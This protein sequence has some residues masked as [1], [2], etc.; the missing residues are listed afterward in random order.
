MCVDQQAVAP[1]C[2]DI[3]K[4]VVLVNGEVRESSELL[5]TFPEGRKGKSRDREGTAQETYQV[6]FLLPMVSPLFHGNTCS[7]SLVGAA[8]SIMFCCDK[9]VFVVTKHVFCHDKMYYAFFVMTN[10]FLS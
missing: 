7:V 8:I 4:S 10:M 1:F 9:L 3:W 6:D 5:A 2:Q